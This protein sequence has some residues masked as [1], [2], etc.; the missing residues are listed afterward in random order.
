MQMH[1]RTLIRS[2]TGTALDPAVAEF[3][4]GLALWHRFANIVPMEEAP[5]NPRHH[6]PSRPLLVGYK[7]CTR[8]VFRLP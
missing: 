4:L 6:G 1:Y 5:P 3:A 2:K 8:S 7:A